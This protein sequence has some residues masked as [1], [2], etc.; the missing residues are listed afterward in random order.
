MQTR[1]ISGREYEI[2]V[3]EKYGSLICKSP[4]I[5]WNTQG[6]N[7][8]DKNLNTCDFFNDRDNFIH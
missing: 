4:K 3:A 8:L 2:K 5:V 6:K 7:N 1:A